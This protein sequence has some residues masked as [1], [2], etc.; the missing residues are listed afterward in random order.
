MVEAPGTAPGSE[1]L[2]TTAFIA[3]AGSLQRFEYM[4]AA[5]EKKVSLQGR[6]ATQAIVRVSECF[7]VTFLPSLYPQN[8][9][10]G[11][12]IRRVFTDP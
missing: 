10:S 7:R 5:S 1:R 12:M 3:I 8:S 2:I 4:T 6:T 9:A 11:I